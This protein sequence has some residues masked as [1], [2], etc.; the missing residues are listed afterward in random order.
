M[1]EVA[2]YLK[3]V[4]QGLVDDPDKVTVTSSQDPLGVLFTVKVN[5]RDAGKVIGKAGSTA[6]MLRRLASIKGY[7][8]DLRANVK[9]DIPE[10]S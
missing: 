10:I 7:R 4:V 9:F 8:H 1:E 5:D 6:H 2:N 3:F